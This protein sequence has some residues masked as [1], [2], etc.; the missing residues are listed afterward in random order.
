[1]T[2]PD[3]LERVL[4]ALMWE[5]RKL[6]EATLVARVDLIQSQSTLRMMRTADDYLAELDRRE[7]ERQSKRLE[8]LTWVLAALTVVLVVI[9]VSR[10]MADL[11]M[12]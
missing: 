10:L 9:E 3:E 7:R 6:D 8:W 5:M 12:D 1:M 2:E 4:Y 11:M